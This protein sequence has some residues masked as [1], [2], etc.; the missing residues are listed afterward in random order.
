[1]HVFGFDSPVVLG[2]S[3]LL[4][5]RFSVAV[6]N[7]QAYC[8]YSCSLSMSSLLLGPKVGQGLFE[9][10]SPSKPVPCAPDFKVAPTKVRVSRYPCLK[11]WIGTSVAE[12]GVF[13]IPG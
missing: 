10:D 3:L 9:Q 6:R 11:T 13:R 2:P 1:M 4:C 5:V 8:F 12:P 7:A